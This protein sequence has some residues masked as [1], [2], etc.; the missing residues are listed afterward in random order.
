MASDSWLSL[1][2]VEL[3]NRSRLN[4]YAL[5]TGLVRDCDCDCQDT[6]MALGDSPYGRI[7]TDTAPWY[8][9]NIIASTEFFGLMPLNVQGLDDSTR[10]LV[11][12]EGVG[13][14][15]AV[16]GQRRRSRD[17]RIH[18]LLVAA[19]ER[20][21]DYG[22][23]WL[24]LALDGC[25]DDL[26]FFSA[27]PHP[28]EIGPFEWRTIPSESLFADQGDPFSGGEKPF[29]WNR[30]T[31]FPV[32]ISGPPLSY[33][34]PP[35]AV[36]VLAENLA[37]NPKPVASGGGWLTNNGGGS[38]SESWVTSEALPFRR[39]TWTTPTSSPAG[40]LI[41]TAS[42]TVAPGDPV[43]ARLTLRH[44]HNT[45]TLGP[46][47]VRF[48]FEF[49]NAAGGVISDAFVNHT[50]V[51]FNVWTDFEVDGVIAP[52]GTDHIRVLA[53]LLPSIAPVA[54]DTT[55]DARRAVITKTPVSHPYFD[56]DFPDEG[57]V[58]YG[59]QGA[60][61]GSVSR[62]FTLGEALYPGMTYPGH[63]D[64]ETI[65]NVGWL[66]TPQV[67]RPL[68]CSTKWYWRIEGPEGARVL[69]WSGSDADPPGDYGTAQQVIMTGRPI[70]FVITAPQSGDLWVKSAIR[71]L[72]ASIT[73]HLVTLEIAREGDPYLCAEDY[74]R[75]LREVHAV[76]GPS[77]IREFN[78]D[79]GFYSEVD[80]LL[81]AHVPQR[82]T[83]AEPVLGWNGSRQIPMQRGVE[84]WRSDNIMGDCQP[85]STVNEDLLIDPDCPPIPAPPML[86][87]P[88]YGCT[89][90]PAPDT[91]TMVSIPESAIATWGHSV[92][93]LRVRAAAS[94]VRHLRVRFVADPFNREDASLLDPCA[95]IGEFH[96]SY[97]PGGS[98]LTLDGMRERAIIDFPNGSSAPAE[99]LLSGPGLTPFE[100]PS[101]RCG[102]RYVMVVDHRDGDFIAL[103]LGLAVRE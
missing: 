19:T 81:R 24:D 17:I 46:R 69:L 88:A 82:Y 13:D 89:E 43:S 20:G 34:T 57:D 58:R 97:I 76:E 83:L 38:V 45:V 99:H 21:L 102:T 6:A 71:S 2:G 37:R 48:G 25:G 79:R 50:S 66:E 14:G 95:A 27:C 36:T 84:F 77:V 30:T 15:G 56:G 52:A 3:V 78:S 54:E 5:G 59:W 73:V 94:A 60:V 62:R 90:P 47:T 92:P 4:A 8:D 28:S 85:I 16:A 22:K 80:F 74:I 39:V 35:P 67:G 10:S 41:E 9:P 64:P 61:N 31:L 93:V 12:V 101:F 70:E 91:T 100:W 42:A 98:I 51:P 75:Q 72:D 49:R 26:C 11:T 68:P 65:D 44:G 96:I 63:I 40:Q 7:E 29:F 87:P 33:P 86:A 32:G 55:L 18:G 53:F 23:R 1:G 103:E